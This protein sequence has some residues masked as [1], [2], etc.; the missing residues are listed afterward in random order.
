MATY[1]TAIAQLAAPVSAPCAALSFTVAVDPSKTFNQI[2]TME[3]LEH[4]QQIT[5]YSIEAQHAGAWTKLNLPNGATVGARLVDRLTAMT[6]VT[7][8]RWNCSAAL[9]DASITIA[10]FA[11]Y[12]CSVPSPPPPPPPLPPLKPLHPWHGCADFNCT[13]HGMAEYYGVCHDVSTD[14]QCKPDRGFGCAPPEAQNWWIH[15]AKPCAKPES[16]CPESAYTHSHGPFPG[17]ANGSAA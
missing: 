2:V 9:G 3:N 17:C 12:E 11:V 8:I 14:T 13:C 6:G 16:C 5:A 7:A 4:G 15:L 10:N 1:G